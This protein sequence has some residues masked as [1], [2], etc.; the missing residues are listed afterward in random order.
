MRSRD[1][2]NFPFNDDREDTEFLGE[3]LAE[4]ARDLV[5]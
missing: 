5:E 4:Y 3:R 1:L 2:F